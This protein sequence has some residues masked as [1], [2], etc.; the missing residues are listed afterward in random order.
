MLQVLKIIENHFQ[1][2]QKLRLLYDGLDDQREILLDQII[3]G[4]DILQIR[5]LQLFELLLIQ[6]FELARVFANDIANVLPGLVC[7]NMV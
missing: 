1:L 7:G 4:F 6:L 5:H 3:N 2:F